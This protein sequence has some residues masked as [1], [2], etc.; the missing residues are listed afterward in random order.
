MTTS[1]TIRTN[2]DGTID[3][4]IAHACDLHIEDMGEGVWSV[5]ITQTQGDRH[6]L[7]A[8]AGAGILVE[9]SEDESRAQ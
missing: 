8:L 2:P 7:F 6:W 4:V 3:E 9:S 1:P 5:Q